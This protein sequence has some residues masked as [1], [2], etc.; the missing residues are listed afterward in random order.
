M[1]QQFT[2]E[3]MLNV[4]REGLLTIPIAGFRVQGWLDTDRDFAEQLEER[5]AEHLRRI[6]PKLEKAR[7][8]ARE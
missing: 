5:I 1:T 2:Y 6:V 3:I 4:E 8:V 7:P